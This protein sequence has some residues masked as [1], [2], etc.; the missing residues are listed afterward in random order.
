M[1]VTDQLAGKSPV[2]NKTANVNDDDDSPDGNAFH[3][4][5]GEGQFC[6]ALNPSITC[7]LALLCVNFAS[8]SSLSLLDRTTSDAA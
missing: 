7:P 4:A 5:A 3:L 1:I 6:T 8:L 2:T